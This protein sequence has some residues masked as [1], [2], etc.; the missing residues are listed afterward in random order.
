MI[1]VPISKN[2][3]QIRKICHSLNVS[4]M[5]ENTFSFSPEFVNWV[6][7]VLPGHKL[8]VK[9]TSSVVELLFETQEDADLFKSYLDA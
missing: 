9:E 1:V 4:N 8:R 6:R 7:D 2:T 5:E 3:P